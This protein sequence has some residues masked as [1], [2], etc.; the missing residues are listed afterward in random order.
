[1]LVRVL[2][3][4]GVGL[5]LGACGSDGGGGVASAG[6]TKAVSASPS[7]SLSPEEAELKFAQCMRQNGINVP[8]PKPGTD[9]RDIRLGGKGVDRSKLE[10]A[11]KKCRPFLEAGGKMPD[12]KDPKVRD[13]ATKFAQCMRQNGIN[14]P[15]PGADGSMKIPLGEGISRE[16]AD[17]AREA[18]RHLMPNGGRR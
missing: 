3:L 18:C 15:D 1:M 11:M 9:K 7:R 13:A 8:D 4:V 2:G 17:K 5:V 14:M 10:A 6:G 16:R 12:L